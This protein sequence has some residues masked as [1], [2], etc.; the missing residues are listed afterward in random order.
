M[1]PELIIYFTHLSHEDGVALR[2]QWDRLCP[3]MPAAIVYG[4]GLEISQ[5][6]SADYQPVVLLE[7]PAVVE[8]LRGRQYEAVRTYGLLTANEIRQWEN[9]S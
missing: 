1:R 7:G 6:V 4:E 9:D 3:E 5:L 2:E 8:Y